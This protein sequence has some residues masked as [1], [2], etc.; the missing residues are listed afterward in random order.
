MGVTLLREILKYFSFANNARMLLRAEVEVNENM[1]ARCASPHK[2]Q[3]WKQK[4]N[5]LKRFS[6][7]DLTYFREHRPKI[8]APHGA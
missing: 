1:G 6:T 5:L 3:Q 4:Q 2:K 8:P 7:D